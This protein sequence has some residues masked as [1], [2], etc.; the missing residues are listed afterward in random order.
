MG[1]GWGQ[2]MWRISASATLCAAAASSMLAAFF[3]VGGCAAADLFSPTPLAEQSEPRPNSILV[4]AG[5][6][7]TTDIYS[8]MVLNLDKL[9][10]H[11]NYDNYVA[12][13]A[14][15]R[16]LFDLGH[17]F[18]FGAEFGVADRFG[19]YKV[20]CDTIIKSSSIVHSGEFWAG[21][22]I[23]WSGILLFDSVRVG[24]AV[25]A[26]LSAATASIGRERQ[27]EIN[28]SGNARFLF[29]LGPE[30]DFS[31]PS[32]PNLEFVLK[33]QHRSGANGTLGNLEEGYNGNV[34][35]IRYRF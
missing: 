33:L 26:G 9:Y 2:P 25:T 18:Y 19:Y 35:G 17:G 15:D 8:T 3:A 29:Y 20:C 28:D 4:F 12:G 30:L 32:I 22:Q 31:A 13:V 16:D 14:Y 34:A 11:P 5:I 23:R 1:S 21:P 27:R 7:S 6:M 24:G 10:Q